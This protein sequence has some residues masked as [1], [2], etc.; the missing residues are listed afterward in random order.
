[1]ADP[2]ARHVNVFDMQLQLLELGVQLRAVEAE[3]GPHDV[4][5]AALQHLGQRAP[6]ARHQDA[7]S[8]QKFG[9][10]R[11]CECGNNNELKKCSMSCAIKGKVTAHAQVK[12]PPVINS[13]LLH[14]W[15]KI[16]FVLF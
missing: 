5:Y 15:P 16:G 7:R 9:S 2:V 12:R 6:A 13:E 14:R 10:D 4:G 1:M 8:F 11:G 3:G